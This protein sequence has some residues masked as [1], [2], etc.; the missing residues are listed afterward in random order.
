MS[1]KIIVQY[2]Y[3]FK[4][5]TFVEYELPS[6]DI[7]N[8]IFKLLQVTFRFEPSAESTVSTGV[9][10]DLALR[11]NKLES[12]NFSATEFLLFLGSSTV[13]MFPIELNLLEQRTSSLNLNEILSINGT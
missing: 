9:L 1:E 8:G 13:I 10:F 3:L 7:V 11:L 4:N 6:G 5:L 12:L 2:R